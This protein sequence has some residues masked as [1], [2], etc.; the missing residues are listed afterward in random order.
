[1][2]KLDFRIADDAAEYLRNV[3]LRSPDGDSLVLAVAPVSSQYGLVKLADADPRMSDAELAKVAREFLSSVSAPVK[4]QWMVGAIRKS[5]VPAGDVAVI[6][7]IEC[8]LP[9]E[10]RRLLNGRTLRIRNGELVF[11]PELQQPPD[12]ARLP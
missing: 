2:K 5:R 3:L 7:G 11:E 9:S 12:L 1:M 10:M 8:F 6:D 4:F